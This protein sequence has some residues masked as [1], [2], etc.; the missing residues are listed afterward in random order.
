M[1]RPEWWEWELDFVSH[2]EDRMEDRGFSE[3]EV[4]AM[5]SDA[6]AIGPSRRARRWLISSRL[7]GAPWTVVV[8]PNIH[9]QV[10]Y[11]ITAFPRNR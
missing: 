11:V 8:E 1:E 3:L 2:A 4:R 9:D 5:L 10:I 7:H 6:T